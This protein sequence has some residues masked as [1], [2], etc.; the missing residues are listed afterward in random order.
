MLTFEAFHSLA[1]GIITNLL[2][3]LLMGSVAQ[4]P[5]HSMYLSPDWCQKVRSPQAVE[6]SNDQ[7]VRAVALSKIFIKKNHN[8]SKFYRSFTIFNF[9]FVLDLTIDCY[10]S[11]TLF[12]LFF[13]LILPSSVSLFFTEQLVKI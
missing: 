13:N 1:S 5:S 11:L 8:C 4:M 6:Q 2:T 12:I 10:F 9:S 7:S 3:L